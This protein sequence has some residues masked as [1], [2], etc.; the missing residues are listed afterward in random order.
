MSNIYMLSIKSANS[1]KP[2]KQNKPF[3]AVV[4]VITMNAT[5]LGLKL[6]QI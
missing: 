4:T 5:I 3:S 1:T 2:K 6:S